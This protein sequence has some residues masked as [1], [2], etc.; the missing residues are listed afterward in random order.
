[1]T[2]LTD[3]HVSFSSTEQMNSWIGRINLVSALY[4]SPPFPAAVGSQKKFSRP[5][6]PATQSNLM[7]VRAFSVR[8]HLTHRSACVGGHDS[9]TK[10]TKAMILTILASVHTKGVSVYM[11][12]A[13]FLCSLCTSSIRVSLGCGWLYLHL[14]LFSS[15]ETAA[16]ARGH[17]AQLPAGP[18]LS[19]AGGVGEQEEQSPGAGGAGR[20]G[21]L[22]YEV[23]V[24]QNLLI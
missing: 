12:V 8:E 23:R 5:I 7:L 21:D 13:S 22:Q 4:S 10:Y 20:G 11:T 19:P 9:I 15:G 17:A 6:L 18:E 16:V 14:L 2:P 3:V 24:C 1:M